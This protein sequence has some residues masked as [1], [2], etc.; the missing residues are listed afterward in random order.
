MTEDYT[1]SWQAKLL[2]AGMAVFGITAFLTGEFAEHGPTTAG[3]LIHAY[4]GLTLTVFVLTRLL[5]GGVGLLRFGAW[6][7]FSSGQWR[8]AVED[9]SSLL[10]LDVPERGMHEGIAGLTQSFGL[11]LF[12]WMGLTGSALFYID[13]RLQHRLFEVVE[14][15]H[16]VGEDLIPVYLALHVGSVVVHSMAARPIWQRMWKFGSK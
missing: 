7:P 9:I 5:A 16:E 6:S 12:A 14:E 8:M 4:L 13:Y 15:L 1:Y 11:M 3:F 2:H 10:R